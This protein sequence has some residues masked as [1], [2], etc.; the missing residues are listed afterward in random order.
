MFLDSVHVVFNILGYVLLYTG[1]ADNDAR[2]DLS[3][4][5]IV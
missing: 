2:Q 1:W 5:A 4:V 3:S